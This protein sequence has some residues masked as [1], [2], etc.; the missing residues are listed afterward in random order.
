M[1][2]DVDWAP[3]QEAR[4]EPCWR[5]EASLAAMDPEQAIDFAMVC[6]DCTVQLREPPTV[7][8]GQADLFVPTGTPVEDVVAPVLEDPD[9]DPTDDPDDL[10]VVPDEPTDGDPLDDPESGLVA[11]EEPPEGMMCPDCDQEIYNA[12]SHV[13]AAAAA[14]APPPT[15]IS[16]D[17]PPDSAPD[18]ANTPTP[19]PAPTGLV[20]EALFDE[21]D[22]RASPTVNLRA[23]FTEPPFTVLDRKGGGWIERDRKWKALG[24]Q[25]ELGRKDDLL[26]YG[27]INT[28]E[29]NNGQFATFASTSIFSPTLAELAV[30]WYSAPDSQVLDPFAGGSVRGL[31]AG[32][33]RRH[34]TGIDLSEEQVAANTAQAHISDGHTPQWLA[35][36]SADMANLLP[37][38]QKYDLIFS[39]PPYAYLE[40]YS[41]DPRDLSSLQYP[42]FL[43]AY[44]R[45]IDAAVDRLHQDRFV[46]W[47]IGEVREKGGH[48]ALGLVPD[49]IKAFQKAGCGL[50]NDHI[51]LTPIGSV[52][53][54]APKQFNASRKAGRI[55]EYMLVFV[56]GDGRRAARWAA[57]QD[58]PL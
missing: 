20:E 50:Y 57:A 35:G 56:K 46:V 2:A 36:D 13:C 48:N 52:A 12:A 14:P 7:L 34:Y 9:D 11:Y 55:H 54:R 58:G 19:A 16:P 43:E 44:Q 42:Q 10:D 8:P 39:C 40:E 51:S 38:G 33:M 15:P 32:I 26:E 21:A 29:Y 3:G 45:I 22:Y 53:L 6:P 24:I 17:E 31:V 18:A 30:R 5:H 47:V 4:Y 41:D 49:T 37:T 23:R 27:G 28:P 25:S 1:S